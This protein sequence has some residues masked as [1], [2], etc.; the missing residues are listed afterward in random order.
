MND[1]LSVGQPL[2][3]TGSDSSA[4]A[5]VVEE[6]RGILGSR[7]STTKAV[8]EQFAHDE[9]HH[10][11]SVPDAVAS[12]LSSEEV[13]AVLAICS[14]YGVPVIPFGTGTGLEGGTT[15]PHGGITLELSGMNQILRVSVEDMDATVQ[16]G[17]TRVQLNKGVNPH[18]LFFS[19]DPGADASIGGMTATRASGTNSVRYGTM[20]ENVLG[21][22]VVLA[23]GRVIT[24]GGQAR[25]SA[26]GYDLTRLFVG[27]EGT[28]GVITEVTVRLY[29]NPDKVAVSA[30]SFPDLGSAVESAIRIAQLAI[31]VAKMELLDAAMIDAVNR[32]SGLDN[33][34]E[35][36]IFFEFQGASEAVDEQVREV[37]D[38]VSE[39][40]G[41]PLMTVDTPE[42]QRTKLWRARH[43]ALRA[44]KS[45]RPNSRILSTD[46]CVPISRL[47]DCMLETMRDVQ[48]S[49]LQAPSAGHVGDGNF[50]LAIIL[51]AEDSDE[52]A[53]AEN[54]HH[55]LVMRALQMGG[56]CTGEHG[57]G[58][59][60]SMYLPL[61]HG[62]GVDVMRDIKKALDPGAI[63]N[64]GK[65]FDS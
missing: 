62:E 15:A 45:L 54:L 47:A 8:R 27:S 59:G 21:L 37:A 24:T 20:R 38:T 1:E 65:V 19:V 42:R 56:T 63:L 29:G 13:S 31:P 4:V 49:G 11:W 14:R 35:P 52:T 17:V 16:A 30:Y 32:Y 3:S 10:S 40:D 5:L 7:L 12:C 57:I 46:A 26:S 34:L 6:L 22:T 36:T 53:R 44:A 28:L 33:P 25:K 51:D 2:M 64:P 39:L 9:S 18:G 23:D 41:S 43:D 58:L 50:H 55:R 61:E 48:A 60:K